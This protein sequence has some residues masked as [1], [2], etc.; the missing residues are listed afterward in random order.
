MF[1]HCKEM[2]ESCI[3]FH[4]DSLP[5]ETVGNSVSTQEIITRRSENAQQNYLHE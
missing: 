2:A 1:G 5:T 4:S 3:S